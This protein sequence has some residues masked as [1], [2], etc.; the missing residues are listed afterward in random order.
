MT[1]HTG[2]TTTLIAMISNAA[3]EDTAVVVA[4]SYLFRS[5]G[6]SIGIS[7]QA[8]ILQQVL[9]TQLALRLSS[10]DE[11]SRIE[12]RFRQSLDYIQQLDPKTA[13]IVRNC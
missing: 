4:C 6:T 1:S 11:A 3:E 8:A 9:R 7:I 2:I 12:E 13:D 5:L 10:G